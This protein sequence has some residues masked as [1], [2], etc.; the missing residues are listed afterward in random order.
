[1]A[2]GGGVREKQVLAAAIVHPG[3]SERAAGRVRAEI[4]GRQAGRTCRGGE[5]LLGE[6]ARQSVVDA[7]GI[8]VA[9]RVGPGHADAFAAGMEEWS[10][11]AVPE[12]RPDHIVKNGKRKRA[13]RAEDAFFGD[14]Q[15]QLQTFRAA[16]EF[17]GEQFFVIEQIEDRIGEAERAA[18]LS[19]AA[20]K[21]NPL[22]ANFFE[23]NGDISGVAGGAEACRLPPVRRRVPRRWRGRAAACHCDFRWL[24]EELGW[25]RS[26][27]DGRTGLPGRGWRV[28]AL[29]ALAGEETETRCADAL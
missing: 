20:V 23:T 17:C 3:G 10:L 11:D 14:A 25:A 16:F 4:D 19:A 13:A 24:A 7:E 6:G 9:E 18:E 21:G 22:L 28:R 26:I 5:G 27:R 12:A 29:G 2:G 15:E 1:E 8:G